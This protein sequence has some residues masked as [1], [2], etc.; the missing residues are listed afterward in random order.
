MAFREARFRPRAWIITI[1]NDWLR[2]KCVR[3]FWPWNMM[4][5]L[6]R[7]FWESSLY[8]NQ[9]QWEGLWT[10]LWSL[11]RGSHFA[12]RRKLG[13]G[14][15]QIFKNSGSQTVWSQDP[16]IFLNITEDLKDLL[17]MW[18]TSTKIDCIRNWIQEIF[19]THDY[20]DTHSL[21]HQRD[22]FITCHVA[23]GRFHCI[24]MR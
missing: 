13:W 20:T 24:L 6:M 22:G 14:Q 5:E 4:E 23:T 12:S 10:V 8:W 19:K 17:L 3:E 11:R 18:V 15:K 16:L 7:D 21:G 9:A 1:A 2:N